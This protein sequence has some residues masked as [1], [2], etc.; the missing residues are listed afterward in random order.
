MARKLQISQPK[1]GKRDLVSYLEEIMGEIMGEKF[2]SSK[3]SLLIS[4]SFTV[5]GN[6]AISFLSLI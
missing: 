6:N 4:V 2:S 5:N 1:P 3:M